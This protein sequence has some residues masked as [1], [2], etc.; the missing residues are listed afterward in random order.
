MTASYLKAAFGDRYK[1]AARDDTQYWRD[2]K[3]RAIS[4]VLAERWQVQSRGL[5]A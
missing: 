1:G 3:T 5:D 2:T 4:D